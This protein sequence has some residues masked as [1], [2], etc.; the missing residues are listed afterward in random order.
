MRW[1]ALAIIAAMMWPS[2][3]VAQNASPADLAMSLGSMAGLLLMCQHDESGV[4]K[5]NRYIAITPPL[6][7]ETVKEKAELGLKRGAG[8]L[9]IYTTTE[10]GRVDCSS[11][12]LKSEL[13][14][15][16]EALMKRFGI[17]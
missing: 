4:D 9:M 13:K 16:F 5:L 12:K 6:F 11:P 10:W 17:E 15:G 3:L 8:E 7:R 2:S 1:T 14:S